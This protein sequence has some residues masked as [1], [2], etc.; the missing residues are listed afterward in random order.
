MVPNMSVV[1]R[2]FERGNHDVARLLDIS[3]FDSW[4]RCYSNSLQML[5]HVDYA[6]L[7]PDQ[8]KDIY[9]FQKPLLDSSRKHLD[10]LYGS[11]SRAGWSVLL[12]DNYCQVLDVRRFKNIAEPKII[13]A[14]RQGA[15]LSEELI[16][17]SA[18]SCALI[19]ETLVSVFGP[20]HYKE[21]HKSFNCAAVPVFDSLGSVCAT[22]NITNEAPNRDVAAFYLLE[23][24]AR[25][26]QN[27]L[28]MSIPNAI[29][30][31]L[32]SGTG[33]F[34]ANNIVLAF[35]YEQTVIGA[36]IVA[37]RFFKLDMKR[38]SIH[39]EGLFDETF[40][41]LFDQGLLKRQTFNLNLTGGIS[42]HGRVLNV[43]RSE[44]GR[45]FQSGELNSSEF[46]FD[47]KGF[48]ENSLEDKNHGFKKTGVEKKDSSA[49]KP[50][51][52][53]QRIHAAIDNGLK[54][55]GRLPVLI[56]GESGVG[57]E[58]VARY[59]HQFSPARKGQLVTLNC[60]S[61]PE[62]L[63]ESELFGYE[64]GSFTGAS[65]EGR[66]G[67]IQQA[68]GGTLL[69]DE[70]GDMPVA[71][72]TRLLRVLETREVVRLGS[73]KSES[74]QFQLICATHKNISDAIEN[75]EFRRDL[76][77]RISG[78]EITI[79]PLRERADIRGVSKLILADQSDGQRQL[80]DEALHCINRY[81]W[82]G[83]VREL[84]NAL[85]YADTLAEP[86][87]LIEPSDLPDIVC[88]Y[89]SDSDEQIE[90]FKSSTIKVSCDEMILEAIERFDGN[91]SQA[92][93]YLGIARS[94]LYRK[95]EKIGFV[96]DKTYRKLR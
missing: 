96:E 4:Q 74:V 31:E 1:R 19:S 60:A 18:M 59:L 69:L 94:T 65:R 85:I 91:L 63:I 55:I 90:N 44:Q 72:Q 89:R 33:Q 16:G 22:V 12:T 38:H 95:I 86:G 70:I 32:L 41:V 20:E 45:L 58:V 53:D 56:L 80:S 81:S 7:A 28:I 79:P 43:P 39:F 64:A 15:V 5:G 8:F 35:S 87:R 51:F 92:A 29:V 10:T 46:S 2:D 30:I 50:Y 93:K 62:S 84:R 9:H 13:D 27:E 78:F 73:A 49:A 23:A 42:L 75:S 68:N 14:F 37:E 71:L 88:L 11:L 52:G 48:E 40:S 76:F 17:T 61:I 6:F 54:A 34:G 21:F 67:K 77:Y 66:A 3:I 47:Q 36:N 82:P 26:I 57:K 83:N 24:C 25:N